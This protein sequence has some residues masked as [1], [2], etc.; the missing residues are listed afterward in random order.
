MRSIVEK[1]VD[2]MKTSET[3]E[4]TRI[5]HVDELFDAS[6]FVVRQMVRLVV[7][8][9]STMKRKKKKILVR[10]LMTI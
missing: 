4:L 6:L 10:F 1:E 2:E 9:K 8:R 7:A 5:A 3:K